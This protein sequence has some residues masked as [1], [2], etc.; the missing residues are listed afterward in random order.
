[1]NAEK[2]MDYSIEAMT[3][4]DFDEVTALWRR[5]EGVG[6]N[7]GDGRAGIAIYLERNPGLSLV[8]R[9]GRQK[10]IGAVL[11]GH[12]GRRGCLYHLAIAAEHR[13]QGIGKS[14]VEACLS[15]LGALGIQK[16]NIFLYADNIAGRVFWERHGWVERLDLRLMQKPIA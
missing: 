11:C 2:S 7:E 4:K 9:D 13:R 8:A 15:K 3:L 5:S 10:I 6:L 14:L 16:C 12:D 1:M